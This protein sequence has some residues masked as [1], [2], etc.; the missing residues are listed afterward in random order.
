MLLTPPSSPFV[1]D[2]PSFL[3]SIPRVTRIIAIFLGVATAIVHLNGV[4]DA[5]VNNFALKPMSTIAASKV[6]NVVTGGF[7][8]LNPIKSIVNIILFLATGK[9][10]E[11]SWGG[12]LFF[13]FVILVNTVAGISTYLVMFAAFV[14]TRIE[15]LL[16]VI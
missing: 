11:T 6:W 15:N 2:S 5:F 1:Q 9:W 3:Q 10:I 13:V 16:Y 4:G 14:A 12:K 7:V 8:E